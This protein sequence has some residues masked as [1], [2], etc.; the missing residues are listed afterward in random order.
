MKI[1]VIGTGY[2]GLVAGTCLSDLGNDVICVDIIEEKVASLRN[3]TVPFYEPGLQ[4]L[5]E[6]NMEQGRLH[7]TTDIREGIEKSEVIFIAVDTPPGK[8]H[9]ADL[10]SVLAVAKSIGEYMNGYKVVVNKST[11][12]VGTAKKVKETITANMSGSYDVDV[13]SNPEFLREGAAVKDFFTPD[14]IVIGTDSERAQKI[15][16]NIY[17]GNVRAGNPL[18]VT[19]IESAELIK[20]AS[21]SFLA[22][23]ISFINEIGRLCEKVGADV[24][25][26]AYGMGLDNRIGPRFLQAGLGYG[27]SCFPKDIKALIQTGVE[28]GA[29]FKILPVVEEINREQRLLMVK[30]LKEVYPDLNGRHFAVWGLAFKP[31]TDDIREAPS[32]DIIRELLQNG[33]TVS[34]FDPVVKDSFKAHFPGIQLGSDPYSIIKGADALLLITEWNAFRDLDFERVKSLMKTPVIIDGRNIYEKDEIESKGFTYL[35]FGR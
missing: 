1:T 28:K 16:E 35:S 17:R 27:G 33:A 25:K 20:Y 32:I 6:I 19:N 21:N 29:Q 24:K 14:R 15:M 8:N 31:K 34:A 11:V 4:D 23:K 26:V 7:F 3:G 30:K 5:L 12:P 9:E 10:T 22:M 18:M 2:V 13:V